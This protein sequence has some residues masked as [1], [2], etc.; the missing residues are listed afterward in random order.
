MHDDMEISFEYV[1]RGS[2]PYQL[3]LDSM[4]ST[5]TCRKYKNEFNEFHNPDTIEL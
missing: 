1:K 4:K 5:D 2:E 3:F